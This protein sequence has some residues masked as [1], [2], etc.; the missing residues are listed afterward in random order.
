MVDATSGLL[1]D[2]RTIMALPQVEAQAI[3]RRAHAAQALAA[4]M[5]KASK[6]ELRQ[7]LQSL[8]LALRV[9]PDRI[10]GSINQRLLV[11]LLDKASTVAEDDGIRIPIDIPTKPDRR[12]HNLKLVLRTGK[13][14]PAK[15]NPALVALLAKAEAARQQLF[16]VGAGSRD[17]K[18]ERVARLAFL[19]PD[20]VSAIVEGR[21]PP[22]LTA[23]RLMQ[24]PRIP[25]EWQ[26]QRKALGF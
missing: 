17:R 20:I 2:E 24:L 25:L 21:H 16:A 7:Q 10:E 15:V 8:G 22:A 5:E 14:R 3:V 4:K 11:A 12:G 1:A 23:R 6:A 19:A 9:H 18:L 26:S 13:E